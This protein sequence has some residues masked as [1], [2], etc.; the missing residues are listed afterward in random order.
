MDK[1]KILY[2]IIGILSGL[3]AGF[4]F[5]NSQNRKQIEN[6]Q[7][8][9]T[10]LKSATTLQKEQG[11]PTELSREEIQG[12][13]NKADQTPND[14][15]LQ[16]KV[17]T[18]LYQYAAMQKDT[19]YLSDIARILKRAAEAK[20]KDY[21]LM[22]TFGNLLFDLAQSEKK[23]NRYIEAREWYQ[24][25]LM[26]KSDDPNVRTDL[27]LTYLFANPS[28]P[29]K[30][31]I[32]FRKSLSIDPKHEPTLQNM[33]QALIK[34]KQY[35]EAKKRIEELRAIN[36]SNQALNELEEQMSQAKS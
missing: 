4:L 36:P 7:N 24:K 3:I 12:A 27:G 34:I 18:Y 26:I 15:E 17:G 32:E 9:I 35:E 25:A 10:N 21:Q 33:I 11:N 6:L 22:V 20:P 31:I 8:E 29:D 5:A 28:E 2:L 16:Q 30:A 19:S 13:I 14:I 23:S 1:S